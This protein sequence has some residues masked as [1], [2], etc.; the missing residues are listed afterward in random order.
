M[1]IIISIF[2]AVTGS[3]G[4]VSHCVAINSVD[5]FITDGSEDDIIS[6]EGCFACQMNGRSRG[7]RSRF[8]SSTS[9][10]SSSRTTRTRNR[11]YQRKQRSSRRTRRHLISASFT[12]HR[13]SKQFKI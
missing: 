9:Y 13:P 8:S 12:S 7:G 6:T 5:D 3:R 4:Q 10:R 2:Q 1:I 11:H